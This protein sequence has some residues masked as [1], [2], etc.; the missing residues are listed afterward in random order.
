MGSVD[1]GTGCGRWVL[2]LL[3]SSVMPY[4]TLLVTVLF[5]SIIPTFYSIFVVYIIGSVS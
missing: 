1:V 5:G 3:D 2:D 4:P